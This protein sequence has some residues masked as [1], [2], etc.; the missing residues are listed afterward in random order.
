[1][2]RLLQCRVVVGTRLGLRSVLEP[3]SIPLVLYPSIWLKLLSART[4][5][6]IASGTKTLSVIRARTLAKRA[7][8]LKSVAT[9]QNI[10][11]LVLVVPQSW[12]TLIGLVILWTLLKPAFPIIWLPCI[13]R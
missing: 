3:M 2:Y 6:F 9:L 5:L 1:M 11:L 8:F 7:W 4:L 12:V 13:L 10:S